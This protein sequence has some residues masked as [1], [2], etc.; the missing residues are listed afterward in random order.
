[1]SGLRAL[2]SIFQAFELEIN[3]ERQPLHQLVNTFFPI[4]EG[5]MTS[6][7]IMGSPE[8]M[9]LIAKIFYMSIQ[10]SIIDRQKIIFD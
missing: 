5:M 1:M 4:L 6:E 7:A 2:K 8:F 3:E 10:V 9:T